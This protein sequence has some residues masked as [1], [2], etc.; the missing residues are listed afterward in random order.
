MIRRS[1]FCEHRMNSWE[2]ENKYISTGWYG[3]PIRW[4][5]QFILC[6]SGNIQRGIHAEK[7]STEWTDA[8]IGSSDAQ[9]LLKSSW[10]FRDLVENF[11]IFPTST[12]SP[13]TEFRG[14]NYG[15][16]T[17]GQRRVWQDEPVVPSVQLSNPTLKHW[18]N[19]QNFFIT[20]CR[21]LWDFQW[22]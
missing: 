11:I 3:G 18:S 2:K 20:L 12:R 8:T 10:F 19:A 6:F 22:V 13:K 4:M 14:K 15:Q 5:R 9:K 16:N 7:A 21:I 17:E 1:H